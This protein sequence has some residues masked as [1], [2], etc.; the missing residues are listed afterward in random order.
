MVFEHF[1]QTP[2]ERS[3][4]KGLDLDRNPTDHQDGETDATE[5][6]TNSTGLQP[7][8]VSSSDE[9]PTSGVKETKPQDQQEAMTAVNGL[10]ALYTELFKTVRAPHLQDKRWYA[11]RP[12]KLVG[13]AR[14]KN[15]LP[16]SFDGTGFFHRM[17]PSKMPRVPKRTWKQHFTDP[18]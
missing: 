11:I 2:F 12:Q 7:D 4:G 10:K 18:A 15:I 1:E 5:A 6:Q 9:F 17:S 14:P 8:A 3:W 13:E 16:Q